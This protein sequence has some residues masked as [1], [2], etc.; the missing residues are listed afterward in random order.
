MLLE[1]QKSR[2]YVE[3]IV[4]QKISE[5]GACTLNEYWHTDCLYIGMHA[6]LERDLTLMSGNFIEGLGCQL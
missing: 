5:Y 6:L 2:E 1:E 4:T 3:Y